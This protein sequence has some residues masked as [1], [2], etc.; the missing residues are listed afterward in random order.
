VTWTPEQEREWGALGQAEH[1]AEAQWEPSG[2]DEFARP[3]HYRRCVLPVWHVGAHEVR[4]V[5]G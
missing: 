3:C 4:E 2:L 5:E 1:E